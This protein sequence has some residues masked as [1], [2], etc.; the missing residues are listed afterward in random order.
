MNFQDQTENEIIGHCSLAEKIRMIEMKAEGK[1][2][3]SICKKLDRDE[4]TVRRWLKR[5]TEERS[6]DAR[7]RTGRTRKMSELEEAKMLVFLQT[8]QTATLREIKSAIG[9]TCSVR[10][11]DDHLKD[12]K[13][14][15]FNASLKPS[16]FPHH[17]QARLSFARFF[18]KWSLAK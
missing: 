2:I 15:T 11:I 13:I 1:P 17:L 9:L 7:P 16:H 18:Q 10:T 3:V 8:H 5:W 12:N 4:M 6:V 14:H